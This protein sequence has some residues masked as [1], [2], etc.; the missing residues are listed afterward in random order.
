MIRSVLFLAAM[1]VSAAPLSASGVCRD[2]HGTIVKCPQTVA[3]TSGLNP[4]PLPPKLKPALNPQPLPPKAAPTTDMDVVI[5]DIHTTVKPPSKAETG[6]N[7][8]PLPPA[9]A[10]AKALKSDK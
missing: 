6:L 10:K 8:Q 2:S 3:T 9:H 1:A 4:Q 7:P 5:G